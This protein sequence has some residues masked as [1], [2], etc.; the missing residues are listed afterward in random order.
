MAKAPPAKKKAAARSKVAFPKKNQPPRESEF[1]ARL[2]LALGKRFE[3][4]RGFLKK[5][6]DVTED[7]YYYGPKTG[8]AWRYRRAPSRSLCS[9]AIHDDRLIGIVALDTAAQAAVPW[10]DLSPAGQK[11]RKIAHGT[12]ALLWIDLPFEGTGAADF[13]ALLKAKLKTMPATTAPA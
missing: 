8:W 5:Q 7:L 4:V 3:S 6:K 12:P 1:I 11:S 9:I 13:K 10:S 2:P